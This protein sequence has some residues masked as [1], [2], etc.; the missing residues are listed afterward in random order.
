TAAIVLDQ[1]H[2]AFARAVAESRAALERNDPGAAGWLLDQIARYGPVGRHL[3]SPWRVA[4]L[5]APNVG[6]SS[7]ANLLAGYQRSVVSPVPGTTRD[8]VTSVIAVDGWPVELVDTA[9]WRDAVESLERQ[10][11]G[12]A[13]AAAAAADLCLWILGAAALPAW[14]DGALPAPHFVVNKSGLPAVWDLG[15]AAASI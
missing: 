4:I 6:K 11:I 10:G 12:L 1:Y 14:P 8:V 2:G 9:G 15:Q 5:G 7:L 13:R 3:A